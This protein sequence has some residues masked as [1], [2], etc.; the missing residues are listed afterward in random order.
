ML[1]NFFES[2]YPEGCCMQ[3]CHWLRR[4][5]YR[6]KGPNAALSQCNIVFGC[7][8]LIFKECTFAYRYAMMLKQKPSNILVFKTL[9]KVALF[10]IVFI[11][12]HFAI[13][14]IRHIDIIDILH[15]RNINIFPHNYEF[16]QF[17]LVLI[18]TVYQHGKM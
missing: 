6:N 10:E 8:R 4:R 15:L 7:F 18:Q 17:P 11:L 5:V 13:V 9:K 14:L 1:N 2:P 3:K 16:F 12:V